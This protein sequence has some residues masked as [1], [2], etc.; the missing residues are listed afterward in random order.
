MPFSPL[1]LRKFQGALC[2]ETGTKIKCI[3][4]V[5]QYYTHK[6]ARDSGALSPFLTPATCILN[7]PAM[8]LWDP[9]QYPQLTS[10]LGYP[11]DPSTQHQQK[12][13][14]PSSITFDKCA[15]LRKGLGLR[16]YDY[17]LHTARTPSFQVRNLPVPSLSLQYSLRT[18]R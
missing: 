6:A 15:N 2:L 3:L 14:E 13:W 7:V 5:S 10:T 1:L 8:W 16:V 4:I 11:S 18:H 9:P 17:M 12:F